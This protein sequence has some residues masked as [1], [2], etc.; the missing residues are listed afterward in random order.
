MISWIR[1]LASEMNF[2]LSPMAFD[3]NLIVAL[4]EQPDGT[5]VGGVGVGPEAGDVG[6][7]PARRAV[8]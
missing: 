2:F 4:R 3:V 5:G 7:G 6:V 1:P 8:S